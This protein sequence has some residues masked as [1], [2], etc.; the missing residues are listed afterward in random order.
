MGAPAIEIDPIL[1]MDVGRAVE[2]NAYSHIVGFQYIGPLLINE[3]RICADPARDFAAGPILDIQKFFLK[4]D[5]PMFG[6]EQWLS[7]MEY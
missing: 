6:K 5:E 3:D 1:I 2:T 7:T 4:L